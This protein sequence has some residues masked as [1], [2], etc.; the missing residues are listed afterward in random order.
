MYVAKDL[1]TYKATNLPKKPWK[2][3]AENAYEISSHTI[4]R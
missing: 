2:H 1:A 4:H 3:N